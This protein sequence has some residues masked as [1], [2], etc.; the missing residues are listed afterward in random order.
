MDLTNA[1]LVALGVLIL[2]ALVFKGEIFVK[3]LGMV[4]KTKSDSQRS[5]AGA[6]IRDAQAGGN[7]TA[8]DQTGRGAEISRAKA[9]GDMTASS[10]APP[11]PPPKA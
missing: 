1:I 7:M 5:N 11:K 6:S 9:G 4:F 3:L 8:N 10:S 2:F